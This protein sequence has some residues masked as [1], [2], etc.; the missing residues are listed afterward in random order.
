MSRRLLTSVIL[1]LFLHGNFDFM[2]IV[3]AQGSET[4]TACCCAN[5]SELDGSNCPCCE[6]I[7]TTAAQERT[8]GV[9]SSPVYKP[10]DPFSK[11]ASIQYTAFDLSKFFRKAF[12]K[13]PTDKPEEKEWE[14]SESA[15]AKY[16]LSAPL[17]HPP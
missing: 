14:A 2:L 4:S 15:F 12:A 10:C 1:L 3:S 13:I 7:E 9:Y 17:F 8:E 5:C 16:E 11:D 6:T